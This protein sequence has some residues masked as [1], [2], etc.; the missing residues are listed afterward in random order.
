MYY[1]I[2]NYK[3]TITKYFTISKRSISQTSISLS[4]ASYTYNSKPKRPIVTVS[5][6]G[7]RIS[8]SN[9]TVTYSNNINAGKAKKPSLTVKLGGRTLTLN[10]D[11]KASYSNNVKVGTATVKIYGLGNYKGMSTDRAYTEAISG[12]YVDTTVQGC[13]TRTY[14]ATAFAA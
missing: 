4:T 10:K 14:K 9:Y 8:S 13:M 12:L 6:S 11:N 7:N 5:I 2:G 1:C 3:G